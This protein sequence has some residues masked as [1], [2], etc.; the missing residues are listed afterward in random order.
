MATNKKAVLN[1]QIQYLSVSAI[2]KFD[3]N[4]IGGCNRRWYYRYVEGIPEPFDKAFEEGQAFHSEIERYLLTGE[5][6]LSPIVRAGKHFIPTPSTVDVEVDLAKFDPRLMLGDL[7]IEGRIDCVNASS[8]YIDSQGEIIDQPY[9]E[10]E[11]IDW[12][13]TSDLRYAKFGEALKTVQM[14]GYANAIA[15]AYPHVDEVRLSQVFFQK[16]GKRA[17]TK[18]SIVLGVED[19]RAR[20]QSYER[21]A[22]QMKIVANAKS[23]EEVAPH[24]ASCEAFKGCPYKNIC[25]RSKAAIIAN[26]TRG[27]DTMGLLDR[28]TK[29]TTETQVQPAPIAPVV[30]P[31]VATEVEKLKAEESK[32]VNAFAPR[33]YGACDKCNAEVNDTNGTRTPSGRIVHTAG[34][35]AANLVTP[36]DAP[37]S[38]PPKS[39]QAI[40]ANVAVSPEIAKAAEP[41]IVEGAQASGM[42]A[43]LPASETP[44]KTRTK[45]T[46][47]S[48]PQIVT[49]NGLQLFVD[50]VVEGHKT[51]SLDAYIEGLHET[52]RK[53]FGVQDLRNA[54]DKNSPLAFGGWKGVL[55]SLVKTDPPSSGAYSV[56]DVRESEVKQVVVEALKPLCAMY[57]RGVR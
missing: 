55:A 8:V 12:K 43:A 29:K 11:V 45:K 41:F 36:P 56:F 23:A 14:I 6:T 1:G 33:V 39:A 47:S 28:L 22:D 20:W 57:A 50:C 49:D 19:A 44:K 16:R 38:E 3:P 25:P 10:I 2:T 35:V 4:E 54:N 27:D 32:A 7:P 17:S 51:T 24:Y 13:S 31:A 30:T 37:V 26:L 42:N 40:P 5:D 21:I 52:I 15:L 53:S 9:N 48:E 34:C 18:N 46:D